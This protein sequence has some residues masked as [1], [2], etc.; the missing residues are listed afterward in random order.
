MSE[1][2]LDLIASRPASDRAIED[3]AETFLKYRAHQHPQPGGGEDIYCQNLTSYMGERMGM[4]LARLRE[5]QA[6]LSDGNGS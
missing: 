1:T 6:E 3:L 5:L 2:A 4:A